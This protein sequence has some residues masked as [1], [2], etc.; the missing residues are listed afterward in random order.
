MLRTAYKYSPTTTEYLGEIKI[1][2]D[3]MNAS[4]WLI[5][6]NVTLSIPPDT[7][8]HQIACWNGT[9]WEAKADYR[10]TTYYKKADQTKLEITEIGVAPTD[11]YTDITPASP[12]QVWDGTKWE[13]PLS[14][15]KTRKKAELTDARDAE[16]FQ[17]VITNKGTFA[18]DA[19]SQSRLNRAK[20]AMTDLQTRN[21]TTVD[22]VVVSMYKSDFQ[23]ISDASI[24]RSDIAFA[25][26]NTLETQVDNAATIQEV[27]AI[28]W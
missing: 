18:F 19:L 23:A 22:K 1:Q 14:W 2:N 5:P 3:P 6:D 25:K 20:E 11:E 24:A 9:A 16:E 7:A 17:N 10:G 26:L 27:Q 21:W 12:D 15:Y 28:H 8:E 13:Y 4:Q